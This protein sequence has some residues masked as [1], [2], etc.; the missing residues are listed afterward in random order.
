MIL[1]LID[2]NLKYEKDLKYIL[3]FIFNLINI[4]SLY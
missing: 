1:K 3:N 2:E 4:F